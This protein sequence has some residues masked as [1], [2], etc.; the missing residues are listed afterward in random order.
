[1]LHNATSD[2]LLV[3]CTGQLHCVRGTSTR[4][5]P[6]GASLHRPVGTEYR[7]LGFSPCYIIS[8]TFRQMYFLVRCHSATSICAPSITTNNVAYP[9]R[10]SLP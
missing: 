7:P 10:A 9:A 8:E 5:K 2:C 4:A 1:M 6:R 3:L